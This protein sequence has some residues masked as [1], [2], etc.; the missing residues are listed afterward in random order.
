[1]EEKVIEEIK[2]EYIFENE[3][4]EKFYDKKDKKKKLNEI[5]FPKEK[6]HKKDDEKKSIKEKIKK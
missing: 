2:K 3:E 6:D 1:M 5:I 4:N